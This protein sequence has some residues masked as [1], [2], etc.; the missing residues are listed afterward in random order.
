M[1]IILAVVND[2]DSLD[3]IDEL[4]E[5]RFSVT[6]L[7][8]TGGFLKRGN[9]TFFLGVEDDKVEEVLD[10]IRRNSSQRTEVVPNMIPGVGNEVSLFASIPMEVT[11][12]GATVFILP[13]DK[14]V[15]L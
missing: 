9:V 7:S 3:V 11:V 5:N 13:A 1:K 6:K 14:M 2:Q 4:V 8:S 15:R 12:G 10:I